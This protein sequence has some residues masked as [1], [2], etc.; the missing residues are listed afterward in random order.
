MK[1]KKR[2]DDE[3]MNEVLSS[4]RLAWSCRPSME[5]KSKFGIGA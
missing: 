5:R 3:V 4:T 2:D 1:K